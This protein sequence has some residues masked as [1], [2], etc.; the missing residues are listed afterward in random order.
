MHAA[1]TRQRVD[2]ARAGFGTTTIRLLHR[3]GLLSER[4][5]LSHAVHVDDEERALLAAAGAAVVASPAAEMKLGD[6]AAQFDAY[7][8]AGITLALGTDAAVCNNG[9]DML[10]ECRMLGLLQK[11]AFGAG[12][13]HAEAILCAATQGGAAALGL[14]GVTGVVVPGRAADLVLI[15][16]EN[17]RLQPLRWRGAHP[18][19]VTNIVYAATGQDVTDVM[20]GGRWAVR[21]RRFVPA[22]TKT[23]WRELR[24]AARTLEPALDRWT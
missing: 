7:R 17:P 20:I 4:V 24:A 16:A 10:L 8:R 6:G 15:D 18:N 19:V 13:M 3:Y 21:R 14:G 12:A 9:T 1:E 11:H 23:L 2:L 5:L 22:D